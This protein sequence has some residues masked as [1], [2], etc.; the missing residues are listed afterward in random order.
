MEIN[1]NKNLIILIPVYNEAKNLPNQIK[2][3][4]S[5]GFFENA[6]FIN[7]GSSDTSL[8]I[9]K[10]EDGHFLSYKNNYGVG[11]ALQIGIRHAINHKKLYVVVMAGDNQDDPE[12]IPRILDPII[13]NQE[14]FIQGSRYLWSERH[15]GV[16][17]KVIST[18]LYSL[19][20][21]LLVGRKIT[22]ASNGFRSFRIK[23]IE[24]LKL[25][26]KTIAKYDFEPLLL[27]QTIKHGYRFKEI[28]VH[29]YYNI[30]TGF[31]KMKPI[32]DWFSILKPLLFNFWRK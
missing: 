2:R 28:A 3:L 27:L 19:L 5:S 11:M 32:T 31:T 10:Q 1:R 7:D 6:L 14:D 22:D 4:K 15:S 24:N 17:S 9:I 13:Y 30:K 20:F 8:S 23:I 29:K 16:L 25:T 21:S 18:K 26:K 12:E